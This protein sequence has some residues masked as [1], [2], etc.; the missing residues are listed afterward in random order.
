MTSRGTWG[1]GRPTLKDGLSA[2]SVALLLIP[3]SMAYAELAGLPGFHGLYASA[4]PLIA[5]AVFVSCPYLQTGPVALTSLLTYGALVPLAPAGSAE[6]VGAAALLALIVGVS[7]AVLGLARAGWVSYL[8]SQPVLRGFTTGA[9]VLIILSQVPAALGVEPASGGPVQ[10][11]VEALAAPDKW[12]PTAVLIAVVSLIAMV[13]FRYLGPLF[14]GALVVV[15]GGILMANGLEYQGPTVGEI[16]AGLPPLNLGLPWRMAPQLLLPGVIIALV[17]FADAAA[18]ARTFASRERKHWDP[19]RE[20]LAQ[21]TANI[22]AGLVG[23]LPV[24]GSFSRSSLAQLSGATTRWS[25]A[26][27]GLAV[28]IFLPFTHLVSPL[29]KAVLSAIVVVA[30]S[31]LVRPRR[32]IALWQLS[33]G[34]AMVAWTTLTLCLLLA[35][36]IEQALLLGV[37]FSLATHVW[38]ERRAAFHSQVEGSTLRIRAVGVLWFASAPRLQEEILDYLAEAG[39]VKKVVID[40]SGL[41]RIDLSGALIL[42]EVADE[43][44]AAGIDVSVERIPNHSQR[45]IGNVFELDGEGPAPS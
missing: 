38:R 13:G 44:E 31:G 26:L 41:G 35:P 40:L 8:M 10:A 14:P 2:L 20:F 43:M 15:I 3:Q 28:L 33:K 1:G 23:G 27:T 5:A 34:Q 9:A 24:G 6:F 22:V 37:L 39:G 25:G 7:R 36:R 4:I 42:K 32:L 16:P 11:V 45:I 29:P 18:I 21:G 19:D 12:D 17:G 30:V